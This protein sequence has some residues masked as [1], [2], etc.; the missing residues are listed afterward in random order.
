MLQTP[1]AI[2]AA[3]E[4]PSSASLRC[5]MAPLLWLFVVVA[6]LVLL[7]NSNVIQRGKTALTIGDENLFRRSGAVHLLRR[8]YRSPFL[9]LFSYMGIDTSKSLAGQAMSDTAKALLGVTDEGI[10]WDK[11]LLD[12]AKST[13]SP[14]NPCWP[15]PK[16]D[17]F[18]WTDDMQADYDD[19]ISTFRRPPKT[20]ATAIRI[21]SRPCTAPLV[22]T[23]VFEEMAKNSALVSAFQNNHLNSLNYTDEQIEQ[24]YQDNQSTFNVAAYDY[25]RF[26]GTTSA[27]KDENGNT[28][29]ATQEQMD[30]AI[31]AAKDGA[32]AALTRFQNGES[33]EAIAKDYDIASYSSVTDGA[34]KG[35]TL[36][37]WAFDAARTAGE[38]AVL[39]DGTN[40]YVAQFHSVGRQEYNTVDV[41]HILI[42]VD[43]STL[44]SKSDT[45]RADLA[46]LKSKKEGRGRKGPSGVEGRRRHRGFLRGAG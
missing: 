30:A 9:Q 21:I 1:K 38:T 23:G 36:S 34:N 2:R 37:A 39:N 13:W 5:S 10:T 29:D 31:A 35:D 15:P 12:K 24:Y 33:L 16:K 11:Y 6:V 42:R 28:V 14:A 43:S 3:E 25:I 27:T 7:W 44:D 17:G 18:T 40:Y 4:R 20:P 26:S 45:Y 32:D 22:T 19:L 41:R 46:D 8:L